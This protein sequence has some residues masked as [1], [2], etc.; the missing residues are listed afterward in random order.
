MFMKIKLFIII[1]GCL[2]PTIGAWAA[3]W[4]WYHFTYVK[5][6]VMYRAKGTS[7]FKTAKAGRDHLGRD[8]EIVTGS[9]GYADIEDGSKSFQARLFP[10]THLIMRETGQTHFDLFIT[11]GSVL[12]HNSNP[13]LFPNRTDGCAIYNSLDE[14]RITG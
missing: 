1:F 12:A 2:I 5:G 8:M 10:N 11:Q 13:A 6:S 9:D 14:S 3:D 4:D 7:V